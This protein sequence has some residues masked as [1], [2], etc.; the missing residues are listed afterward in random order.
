MPDHLHLFAAPSFHCK[1]SFNAWRQFWKWQ[2]TKRL[3]G[4][5]VEAPAEPHGFGKGGHWD[6]RLRSDEN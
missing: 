1:T 2:F 6:R 4:E 3:R 5:A